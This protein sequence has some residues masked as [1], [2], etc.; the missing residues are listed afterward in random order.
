MDISQVTNSIYVFP[1]N[2]RKHNNLSKFTIINGHL[3][4]Y[5]VRKISNCNSTV[6]TKSEKTGES[7]NGIL[8]RFP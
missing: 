4:M 7:N 5:L 2:Y 6:T 8:Y 3:F 1:S